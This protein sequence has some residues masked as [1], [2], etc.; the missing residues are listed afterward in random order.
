MQN[1]IRALYEAARRR[2]DAAAVIDGAHTTFLGQL[3]AL[4][5]MVDATALSPAGA[6][7]ERARLIEQHKVLLLSVANAP[8]NQLHGML[9]PHTPTPA[10][11]RA[12]QAVAL[13]A[14]A[15][16]AGVLLTSPAA[17]VVEA[18]P[19]EKLTGPLRGMIAGLREEISLFLR[20]SI[21]TFAPAA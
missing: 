18:V 9:F 12:A 20:A 1:D 19:R 7:A 15:R 10:A 11:S 14:Q 6:A 5:R 2:T 13:V 4:D 8:E 3:G 21:E 16:A 17:N